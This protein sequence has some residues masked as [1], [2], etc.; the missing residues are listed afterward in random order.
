MAS[1]IATFIFRSNV[2]PNL[3]KRVESRPSLAIGDLVVPLVLVSQLDFWIPHKVT[4]TGAAAA[5][6]QATTAMG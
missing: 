5:A 4:G 2:V 1:L 6:A 3:S